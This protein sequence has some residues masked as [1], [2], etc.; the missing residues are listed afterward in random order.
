MQGS[1]G[2]EPLA[3]A[4]A[5]AYWQPHPGSRVQRKQERAA[6]TK[7][8]Q[9]QVSSRH[10][11]SH[12]VTKGSQHTSKGPSPWPA[13]PSCDRELMNWPPKGMGP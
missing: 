4:L 11:P 7:S 12:I 3:G 2:W 9:G 8:L 10:T 13:R 1:S 6:G 5:K